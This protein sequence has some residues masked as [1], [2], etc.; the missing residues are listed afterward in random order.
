MNNIFEV[1]D[2]KAWYFYRKRISCCNLK[3]WKTFP[4]E[5]FVLARRQNSQD[6]FGASGAEGHES[7]LLINSYQCSFG[8]WLSN[9]KHVAF[10]CLRSFV[11]VLKGVGA[12]SL[13]AIH[14]DQ[15]TASSLTSARRLGV[16]G[17]QRWPSGII[18]E[19]PPVI[20]RCLSP[21]QVAQLYANCPS[22]SS[23]LRI[24][25]AMPCRP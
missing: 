16:V 24:N 21:Q 10:L 13:H 9:Y 18:G 15:R 19:L 22:S 23:A 1:W 11:N 12:S 20:C 2:W 25:E 3:G 5:V 6:R 4:F 8:T 14:D 17:T 7:G